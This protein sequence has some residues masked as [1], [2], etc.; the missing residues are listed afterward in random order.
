MAENSLPRSHEEAQRGSIQKS[1]CQITRRNALRL[2]S[3]IGGLGFFTTA[4]A[5]S[6]PPPPPPTIGQI[7]EISKLIFIGRVDSIGRKAIDPRTINYGR[8]VLKVQVN[9][10]LVGDSQVL[11]ERI[12]YIA[13]WVS[14]SEAQIIERYEG[15]SFIF[16]GE[17]LG[18]SDG[19]T[20]VMLPPT[21]KQPY[22]LSTG[23]EFRLEIARLKAATKP[24]DNLPDSR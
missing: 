19:E 5:L 9:E 4:V 7:V 15:R 13:G 22:E 16:F 11:P 14:M 8:I 20:I 23:D 12:T 2:A 1:P 17:V 21:G 3:W 24:R 10:W 6:P 18:I